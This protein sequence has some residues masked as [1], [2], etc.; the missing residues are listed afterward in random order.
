MAVVI[1]ILM[2]GMNLGI[3]GYFK[4]RREQ[5]QQKELEKMNRE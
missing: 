5:Q 1:L 2:L 3:K 4:S